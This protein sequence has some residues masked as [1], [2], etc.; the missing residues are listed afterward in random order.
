MIFFIMFMIFLLNI[1]AMVQFFLED[2]GLAFGGRYSF[3]KPAWKILAILTSPI[4]LP[5][6]LIIIY[7]SCLISYYV[8]RWIFP[9]KPDDREPDR[10]DLRSAMERI[11]ELNEDLSNVRRM[12]Q[13][14]GRTVDT[15]RKEN[16]ELKERIKELTHSKPP[17]VTPEERRIK[18]NRKSV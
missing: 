18:L 17:I 6:A 10:L 5:F 12:L 3:N 8:F 1:A 16:T 13:N 2:D 4:G 11:E 7:W 9:K 15:L 14:N